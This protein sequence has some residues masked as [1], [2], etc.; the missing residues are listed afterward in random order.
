[1]GTDIYGFIECRARWYEKGEPWSATVDLDLLYMGRSYDT[2]RRASATASAGSSDNGPVTGISGPAPL[3]SVRV[4]PSPRSAVRSDGSSRPA[5][6]GTG[7]PSP[8][9]RSRPAADRTP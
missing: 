9:F 1:M 7:R 8:W 6:P 2:F 5:G 3:S 4:S